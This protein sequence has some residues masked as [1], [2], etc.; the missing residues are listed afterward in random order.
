M[1]FL[2]I[3][4]ARYVEPTETLIDLELET[5]EG[6]IP[7]TFDPSDTAP[8]TEY[9]RGILSTITPTPYE[10]PPPPSLEEVK[11]SK[12]SEIAALR[13]DEMSQPTLVEGYS[14][15]WY[16][17]KDS[18]NDMLRASLDLQT[19]ISLGYFPSDYSLQWK[20]ADGSFTNITLEDLIN[21]RL[22][23]SQRQQG[24]YAKEAMLVSQ[25]DEPTVTEE[26]LKWIVWWE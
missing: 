13:W 18:M 7:F 21:L 19:A 25:I 26:D 6:I 4:N 10:A 24:L 2:G 20:T 5:D 14:Q 1:N 16:S 11:A 22:L 23:L 15:L 3:G 17:D 9:V 8:A 12:K